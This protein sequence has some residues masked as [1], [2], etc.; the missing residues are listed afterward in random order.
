MIST[1]DFYG[2]KLQGHAAFIFS[3]AD[4]LYSFGFSVDGADVRNL[5][6][7]VEG[8]ESTVTGLLSGQTTIDGRGTDLGALTG[9]GQLT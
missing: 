8:R 1:P 9:R 3:E 6:S 5:L 7:A 4:P 2:G